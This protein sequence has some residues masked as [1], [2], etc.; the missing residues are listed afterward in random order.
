MTYSWEKDIANAHK[1]IKRNEGE[2][3]EQLGSRLYQA[4]ADVLA[5]YAGHDTP[6][7]SEQ[8]NDVR[9]HWI[10]VAAEHDK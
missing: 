2:T 3:D 10:E 7:W 4:Q 1:R 6:S 5:A 8:T 9:D